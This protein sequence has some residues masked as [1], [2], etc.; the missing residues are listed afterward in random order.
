MKFIKQKT[1]NEAIAE[2]MDKDRGV[3]GP[4][5]A[6]AVRQHQKVKDIVEKEEK[7]RKLEMPNEDRF[8]HEKVKG[9]AEQK[10]MKLSE[11]LFTE[12]VEDDDD[13]MDSLYHDASEKELRRM[14]AFDSLN[15]IDIDNIEDL[16]KDLDDKILE[17]FKE[18]GERV[19]KDS[20]ING[21]EDELNISF[22]GDDYEFVEDWAEMHGYEN[23]GDFIYKSDDLEEELTPEQKYP[24]QSPIAESLTESIDF[25]NYSTNN[26]EAQSTLDM[27]KES[28]K[29]ELFD[30]MAK[31]KFV[32]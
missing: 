30:E 32:N 26:K 1:L 22:T 10:K 18:C 28:N 24:V 19:Y 23:D 13:E 16:S 15:S 27:I 2:I 8:A 14:G 20:F 7:E 3:V 6:D 25:K 31:D 9:T 5:Y 4:V 12:W 11:S 17:Y 21:I 29:I